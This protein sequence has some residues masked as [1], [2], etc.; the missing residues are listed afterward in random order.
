LKP[1]KNSSP[2]IQKELNWPPTKTRRFK[3][4]V[5]NKVAF[6]EKSPLGTSF[7]IN[8]PA[9]SEKLKN[10]SRK[11]RFSLLFLKEY[12]DIR[13]RL[14]EGE[15]PVQWTFLTLKFLLSFDCAKKGV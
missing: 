10:R 9:S 1:L 8:R 5:T 7:R 3:H 13:A 15:K 14:L 11:W 12:I 6:Q 2:Q 4:S